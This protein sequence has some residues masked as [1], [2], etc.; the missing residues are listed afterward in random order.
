[1][2]F[3]RL[4]FTQAGASP[5]EVASLERELDAMPERAGRSYLD[6]LAGISQYDLAAELDAWREHYENPELLPGIEAAPAPVSGREPAGDY[7]ETMLGVVDPPGED[8]TDPQPGFFGSGGIV[9]T[10]SN[11]PE[12]HP[13]AETYPPAETAPE[14]DAASD[15][16]TSPEA[17]TTEPSV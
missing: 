12:N 9:S 13:P 16:A 2:D 6:R 7:P 15:S 17:Q 1:M 8:A 4:R 5:E 11:V 3:P 10:L 14:P